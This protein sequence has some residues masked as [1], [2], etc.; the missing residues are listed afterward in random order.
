MVSK[1]INTKHSNTGINLMLL[2]YG[3]RT[4]DGYLWKRNGEFKLTLN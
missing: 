4:V 2:F 1:N 3:N